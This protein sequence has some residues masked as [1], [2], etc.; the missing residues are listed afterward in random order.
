[1]PLREI[2]GD[3][4]QQRADRGVGERAARDPRLVRADPAFKR[5][6]VDLKAALD[7]DAARGVHRF[8][9]VTRILDQHGQRRVRI[10]AGAQRAR[11]QRIQRRRAARHMVRK[12]RR[13]AE[14]EGQAIQ[15]RGVLVQQ[16][17]RLHARLHALEG[18]IQPHQRGIGLRLAGEGGEQRW[19]QGG[20]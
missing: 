14:Q 20:Q 3:A 9:E 12:R 4:R 2:G 5:G 18:R 13:G 19:H 1:M 11:E 8:L 7:D 10:A 17:Q 15:Q 16:A 6:S